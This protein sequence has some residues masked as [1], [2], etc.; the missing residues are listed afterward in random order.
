MI[1]VEPVGTVRSPRA[2]ATDDAW[3]DVVSTIELN[4]SVDPSALE[5]LEDFSHAEIL[6]HLHGVPLQDIRRGT[7][8]PR[9]NPAFPAVGIFAQRGRARPNR[10]GVTIVEIV[11]R[12]GRELTVRGL[13]AIDGTPV[14]DI[15]P[16]MVEFLPRTPVRQ[17]AW[18]HQLMKTYWRRNEG[19]RATS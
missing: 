15:K 4:D 6:F 9:N 8:H 2:A 5:G 18:S 1:T 7:R 3:G 10:L 17:P 14:L 12:R 11:A 19:T 13:D 16:V